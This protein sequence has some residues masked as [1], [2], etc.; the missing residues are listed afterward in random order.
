MSMVSLRYA[1]G[2][3]TGLR[4]AGYAVKRRSANAFLPAPILGINTEDAPEMTKAGYATEAVNWWPGENGLTTRG[5][6]SPWC[7]G[8]NGNPVETILVWNAK[9]IFGVA[10]DEIHALPAAPDKE[11]KPR[12][13]RSGLHSARVQS[14]NI[15]NDGGVFL[16]CCNGVDAPFYFDGTEW[17]D[18][19]FTKGEAGF[20][21]SG[22]FAVI[23]H[24]Q[25]LWWLKKGSQSVFYGDVEA[26]QGKV[27]ELPVGAYLTRGGSLVG[28]G[29]ITQD[30][31]EGSNDVLCIISSEGEGILFAG[32]NPNQASS[33]SMIGRFQI[34]RPLG[35]ARCCVPF[36][37]DLMVM[38]EAG[39]IG[40]NETVSKAFTGLS[41]SISEKIRSYWYDIVD[42]YGTHDG[43]E[44]T[45]YHKRDLVIINAPG[46]R[47]YQQLVCNPKTR[48]WGTLEGWEFA[49]TFREY[50]E[51]LVG[52]GSS[53]PF[54]LD[55]LFMD[56]VNGTEF[57]LGDGI[58]AVNAE[59][60]GGSE[61][62]IGPDM[63]GPLW[64]IWYSVPKP[65]EARV[66]HAFLAIGQ[67]GTKKRYTLARP[68]LVAEGQPEAYFCM[69]TDFHNQALFSKMFD[70]KSY[71]G[72]E[73]Y[74][75]EWASDVLDAGGDLWNIG[76]SERQMRTRWMQANCYGYFCAPKVMVHTS[77]QVVTYTGCDVQYEAGNA[78]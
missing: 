32:D 34:A 60:P 74:T 76:K 72:T 50:G 37:P 46:P 27:Y 31:T 17:H 19:V 61:W 12:L 51:H 16:H 78:L 77:E 9:D 20:D 29:V 14:V 65:V 8:L 66:R 11:S 15:G 23:T 40:I 56:A 63:D 58:W 25:R 28:I 6:S 57:V 38:T 44:I 55:Y 7:I 43:W 67:K 59:D 75:G 71:V 2:Q 45:L 5:G 48:A 39:L 36:G 52:G 49:R 53:A 70:E 47:G 1:G 13:V 73:W 18:A 41:G 10:G 24:L 35:E 21:A 68:Y 64:E 3:N 22:F 4:N 54:A 42:L 26:I 33:F 62:A 30:G 69:D